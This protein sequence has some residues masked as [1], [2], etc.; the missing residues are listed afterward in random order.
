LKD[1]VIF[2]ANFF[3]HL[4]YELSPKNKARKHYCNIQFQLMP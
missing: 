1:D 3:Q 4:L 2:A